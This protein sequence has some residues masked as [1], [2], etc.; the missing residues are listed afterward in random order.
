MDL[1]G[2]EGLETATQKKIGALFSEMKEDA[3]KK[4]EK[5]AAAEK[6]LY[7]AQ[8]ARLEAERAKAN[9]AA[10]ASNAEVA[11]AAVEA[12]KLDAQE[13]QVKAAAEEAMDLADFLM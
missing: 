7:D 4:D 2:S 12:K 11:K 10:A 6:A 3:D 5:K 13:A 1:M 9:A 8:M